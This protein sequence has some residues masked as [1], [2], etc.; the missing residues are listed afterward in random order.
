MSEFPK[1]EFDFSAFRFP[2]PWK[3]IG[4]DCPNCAGVPLETTTGWFVAECR[5]QWDD[6]TL[7]GVRVEPM[8]EPDG[9][10]CSAMVLRCASCGIMEI[11][12][13]DATKA[14]VYFVPSRAT[15]D[16]WAKIRE[17]LR[18]RQEREAL[19]DRATPVG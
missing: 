17:D 12:D 2:D 5:S 11:P 9:R 16:R 3:S 10:V 7:T 13:G 6:V 1:I 14:R 4:I 19:P 15:T 8:V 18:S